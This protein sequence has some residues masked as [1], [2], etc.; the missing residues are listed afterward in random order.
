MNENLVVIQLILIVVGVSRKL[1]MNIIVLVQDEL[2]EVDAGVGD[3]N[4]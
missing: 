4:C 1:L 2:H 3:I